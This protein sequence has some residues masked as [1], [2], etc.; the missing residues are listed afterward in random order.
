MNHTINSACHSTIWSLVKSVLAMSNLTRFSGK[1]TVCS[2]GSILDLLHPISILSWNVNRGLNKNQQILLKTAATG[3]HQ[4]KKFHHF[5]PDFFHHFAF[6]FCENAFR[7]FAKFER[8]RCCVHDNCKREEQ[9]FQNQRDHFRNW[10]RNFEGK[11][12]KKNLLKNWNWPIRT[13][14]DAAKFRWLFFDS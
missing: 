11:G 4:I 13:W 9:P 7:L 5:L 6:T 14:F 1:A 8:R 2:L 10:A 12:S 3:F